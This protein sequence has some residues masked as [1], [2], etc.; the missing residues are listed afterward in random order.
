MNTELVTWNLR[1]LSHVS[2][3]PFLF[4]FLL[5]HTPPAQTHYAYIKC[6]WSRLNC[7]QESK[8]SKKQKEIVLLFQ[9]RVEWWFCLWRSLFTAWGASGSIY[10]DAF[11]RRGCSCSEEWKDTLSPWWWWLGTVSLGFLSQQT[12]AWHWVITLFIVYNS[13]FCNVLYIYFKGPQFVML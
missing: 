4:L 1:W 12:G 9:G 8:Y 6:W 13:D 7:E 2:I 5:S 11:N 3:Y 10:K